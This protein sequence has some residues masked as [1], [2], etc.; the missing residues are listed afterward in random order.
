V[1]DATIHG[2]KSLKLL[3]IHATGKTTPVT[4]PAL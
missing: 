3:I 2:D 1:H 4:S